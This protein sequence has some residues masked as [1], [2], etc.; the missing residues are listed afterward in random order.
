M[1]LCFEFERE[2]REVFQKLFMGAPEDVWR[3]LR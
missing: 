3:F 1:A 2:L